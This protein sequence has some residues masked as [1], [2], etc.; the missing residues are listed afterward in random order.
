MQT[1]PDSHRDLLER[2]V[3]TLATIDD[4]GFPQLTE[5][6]FLAEGDTIRLSLNSSRHK[7]QNLTARPQVSVMIL[8]LDAPHRYLEVR[9]NARVEPDLDYVF[10]DELCVKYGGVDLRPRDRP[11]EH[12]VVV[13]IEPVKVYAVD[14]SR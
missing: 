3:L 7:T 9:G 14:M 1:I 4:A 8:D 10:A 2:P 5:V 13:T 12:R 6:W 11:G